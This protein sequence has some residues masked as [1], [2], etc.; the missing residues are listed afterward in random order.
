[1]IRMNKLTALAAVVALSGGLAACGGGGG[2]SMTMTPQEM[3]EAADGRYETDGTCTSAAE[4]AVEQQHMAVSG[5]ID[6]AM[7]AV[8]G[9]SAT[10]T[11]AEV[12]AAEGLIEAARTALGSADLLSANQV[13]TL[14]GRI[15][16]IE[17]NLAT[18][19]M[20]IADHR[21]M[22]ADEQ[23]RMAE[24]RMAA[25]NAISAAMS[26]VGGLSAMSTDAEV[27][28][29]KDAIQAAKDAVTGATA[30]SMT[31]RDSLNGSISSIETTLAS[32]E[33]AI[34]DHRQ[35]VADDEQR[36]AV[37]DAIDAAMAAVG[38]L[39]AMSTDEE[40]NA[41]KGLIQAAK[42]ALSGATSLL[43]AQQALDHQARIS[44]IEGTLASTEVA[45]AAHREQVDENEETQRVA[46]VAAAR[47]AAMQSYMDADADAMKA[48]AAAMEAE[49][50]APGSQ[51]AMDAQM[52]A[53]AART[54]A[55]LAKAAHDAIMNDMT[56]AQADAQA[57]EAATQA[58]N[59]NSYY[60]A[61]KDE[62]D[63]IQTAKAV[64]EQQEEERALAAAKTAAQELNDDPVDGVTFHYDAVVGKAGDAATQAMNA[65]EAADMAMAAR[66]NYADA[67]EHAE[68]AEQASADAQAALARAMTAKA[69]ADAALADALAATTSAEAEAA[70][71]RLRM[72]NTDL[73]A[74]HTGAN[75]AG[76]AYMAARD[77]AM[78]AATAAGEH[79]LMLFLAANGAHV[80]DDEDTE[81]NET[82]D[83]VASVG[84]AMAAIANVADGNQTAGTTV[85]ITHPGDTVD[86]PA[87]MD[88]PATLET[89]E[90]NEFSEGMRTITVTV[91][92]NAI[93]AEFRETRA[94]MDLNE[95]GDTDDENEEA[96][97]Q[98]AREIDGLGDGDGY[99]QGYE[100]WENDNDAATDTDRAR[101]ILFTNKQKG[102]DSVLEV[103]AATARTVENVAVTTT[104]L[105]M[106]GT[107]SG[108]TY[109]GAEYTPA[110]EAALTGTLTCPS[111]V[112]CSV[113]AT[114]ADDGT[115]TINAVSG[116]VFTGSR[117]A[118]EAVAAAAAT[119][120]N[121]YL[122]FGLWLEDD[123]TNDTFGS[124]AVGG[125]G[126]AVN[127]ANTVT[128]TASYS[129]KAAGAHHRTGDGVNWFHGD[130]RLTADFGAADAAGTIMG[131]I[132]NIRVNGGSAMSD[133]I[134]LREA[135][136]ADGTA[137]FNGAARMGAGEIQADDTVMY[138]YN[139]TWSGSFF[140]ATANDTTTTDV[141]ESIT[142][143]KAAAGTFGVTRTMDMGTM[144]DMTDDIVES[145]VGAFGAHLND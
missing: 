16:T 6:A 138:P 22:V 36:M 69:L 130:A 47:A 23:Q 113:D 102:D 124:F 59:A 30:L 21:Q 76:M 103:A 132:S 107:K 4:L 46:D 111:G 135:D 34:A 29:A 51:G 32:T 64:E 72:A 80:E 10:S 7:A 33:M 15:T 58:G 110:G 116:Y 105:T 61:A 53:E 68:T 62:N 89:V 106:L 52:A 134:H 20:A 71:E 57:D 121:D 41:A 49:E 86:N 129:G 127:V 137:T 126:Y 26:A 143:P 8:A 14:S 27:M 5:A 56:K 18:V 118:V 19:N 65:R 145:F 117:A 3:C 1:M 98:T 70:L 114:T 24:Q 144:D 35:M 13:F 50:T 42:D 43:T 97:I 38:D 109:T 2:S 92:G 122:A 112:T 142:A 85:A 77:A 96:R 25:N 74:E 128:G 141:D 104:T 87:T 60:M 136:L 123:G 40:V 131:E 63:T 84:A 73:T 44:T 45:I 48:E 66:T 88:D 12:T 140:G 11:D 139:G 54:A 93:V 9:L 91:N 67:N 55:N 119:E 115:V 82:A 99:F 100:L 83:H 120:D 28:A 81:A 95:D 125:T 133:S 37:G 79:V 75:G 101:A 31:E 90:N 94:A 39:D 78:D 108:N 17:G